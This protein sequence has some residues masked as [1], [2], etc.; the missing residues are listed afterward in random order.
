MTTP[1]PMPY[2]VPRARRGSG[3]RTDP[4]L[5][6]VKKIANVLD[7]RFVDPVIGLVLPGAGDILGSLLGLYTVT[8]AIRRRM[9]PVIVARMLMNLAI[10]AAI[11]IIPLVGDLADIGFKANKRNVALLAERTEQGGKASTKDWLAVVG[12]ALAFG[13]A[14]GLAIYAV[15]RLVG[16]I[17]GAL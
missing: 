14:I 15:V 16:A 2:A 3:T 10:D 17:A 7:H 5:D 12:A 8:L 9:S 1:V 4:E 6:R 13:L 11:G